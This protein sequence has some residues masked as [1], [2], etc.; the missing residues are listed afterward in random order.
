MCPERET[1]AQ[2]CQEPWAFYSPGSR[3]SIRPHDRKLAP[4]GW[5]KLGHNFGQGFLGAAGQM[6]G[7]EIPGACWV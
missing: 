6:F 1:L 3:H 2:G 5:Q 7:H 4:G